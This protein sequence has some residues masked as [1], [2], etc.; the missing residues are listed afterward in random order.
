MKNTKLTVA[1][2]LGVIALVAIVL[3]LRASVNVET[4]VAYVSVLS[5]VALAALDYRVRW[6]RV[7][8]R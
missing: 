4:L 1:T 5:L 8:S 3:F 7:L 6:T 2:T